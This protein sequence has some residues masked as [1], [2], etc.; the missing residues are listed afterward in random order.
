MEKATQILNNMK[1]STNPCDDF[2]QFVCGNYVDHTNI[3]NDQPWTNAFTQARNLVYQEVKA[4]LEKISEPN[5]F[6]PLTLAKRFYSSCMDTEAIEKDG[7]TY[8]DRILDLLG[9]WPVIKNVNWQSNRFEWKK[10][11]Y[12]LRQIGFDANY[13]LSVSIISYTNGSQ[14]FLSVSLSIIIDYYVCGKILI[15][16]SDKSAGAGIRKGGLSE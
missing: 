12:V 4:T 5:E 6:T 10:A 11:M 14:R 7:L 8:M 9:G 2:Y 13:F 15:A 1:P 3:Q 16:V